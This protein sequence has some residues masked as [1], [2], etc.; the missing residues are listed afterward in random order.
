MTEATLSEQAFA[1]DMKWP[2]GEG[3]VIIFLRRRGVSSNLDGPYVF[4][5]GRDGRGIGG[6]TTGAAAIVYATYAEAAHAAL[7]HRALHSPS[8]RPVQKED[9]RITKVRIRRPVEILE[10]LP[11]D[12]LDALAKI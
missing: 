4:G 5:G 12:V 6:W 8:R 11:V 10:E 2:E 7:N 1:K 9:I 3:Y